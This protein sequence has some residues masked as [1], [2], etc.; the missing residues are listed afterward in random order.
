MALDWPGWGRSGRTLEAALETF[1]TY[2]P[3]YAPVAAAAGLRP[4]S[5]AGG[6]SAADRLDVVARI[7]GNATTEYGA[8][9][10]V[11]PLDVDGWAGD[12]WD[13]EA[14]GRSVALLQAAWSRLDEAVAAAPAELRKGPRGGGRDRDAI[15]EHVLGTEPAYARKAGLRRPAP[16]DRAALD[17]LRAELVDVLRRGDGRATAAS[18]WPA[19][20][21]VRRIAWHALDHAWEIED[22]AAP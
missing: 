10:A 16:A 22:R 21:A 19:P 20:Y 1:L 2:L 11:P 7:P 18:G 15:A 9:G 13:A 5:G 4:P 17:D 8:P 3:R 14:A 6:A 12:A